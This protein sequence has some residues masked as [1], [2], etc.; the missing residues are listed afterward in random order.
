VPKDLLARTAAFLLQ[1]DSKSSYVIEGER[2]PQDRIQRWGRAIGEAGRVP[3]DEAEL[4]RLQRIVIGDERFVKLGLRSEG[5]FVG[6]HDRETRRPIPDHISARPEDL[7]SLVK[8]LIAFD[9]TAENE[10]DPVIAAAVLAF[11]FV[12]I[13]PFEDGNGR[14]HRYLM[15]HVLA[16][17]GFNPPGAHFPVS[18]A[19]LDRIDEYRGVLES[20][21]I[22]L[23]PLVQW[24]PTEKGNVSILNDTGDFYRFF[25]ATPH[26]EFLYACVRKTID[27]DLPNETNFLKN[28]DQFRAGI[29]S[30]IDMPERTL[31]NLFGFLRQNG[32]RLSKRAL[33]NEFAELTPDE[34]SKIEGLYSA[35][36]GDAEAPS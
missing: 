30:M 2:P 3:L 10:L 21:S 1:K 28:F 31:N 12:Y 36:F 23:L 17:R 24:E 15:H 29:E 8:G 32:G 13:H 7:A 9:H 6:E 35:S 5:G 18:A 16:R 11:G 25:D 27:E 14:I 34:L 22:R 19:I 26:A 20:Y 4:L 33:E